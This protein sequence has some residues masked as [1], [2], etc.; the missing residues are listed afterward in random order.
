[1]LRGSKCYEIKK[2]QDK[3]IVMMGGRGAVP[4]LGEHDIEAEKP[5]VAASQH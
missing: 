3:G 1:M 5:S 4:E 2:N